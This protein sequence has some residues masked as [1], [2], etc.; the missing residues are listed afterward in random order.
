MHY[1]LRNRQ[2][3]RSRN[4][5][6]RTADFKVKSE[7]CKSGIERRGPEGVRSEAGQTGGGG[8]AIAQKYFQSL[9]TLIRVYACIRRMF[10]SPIHTSYT[11]NILMGNYGNERAK[12][13]ARWDVLPFPKL[14]PSPR[15]RQSRQWTNGPQPRKKTASQEHL[16]SREAVLRH[17]SALDNAKWEISKCRFQS[18][19]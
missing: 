15:S 16:C 12:T 18:E 5:S 17:C 10:Y 13:L 19:K 11:F 3:G 7:K 1:L 14:W 9:E 4:G 2:P 6:G 8:G